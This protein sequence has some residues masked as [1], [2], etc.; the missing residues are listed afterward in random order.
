MAG[1]KRTSWRQFQSLKVN[2][3][4]LSKQAKRAHSSTVRHAHKFIVSRW[5]NIRFVRRHVI[6][7]LVLVGVLIAAVGLQL[8]W[9][10]QGYTVSAPVAGGTYAEATLGPVSSLN[11]LYVATSAEMSISRL[12]FSSLYSYDETGHLRGDIATN[13]TVNDKGTVYTLKLR[14][15]AR[16]HDG[17]KLTA[18]DVVYTVDLIK[19]PA[20]RSTITG[21]QDINA[22]AL[23]D[24]TVEFTLPA[25]YASFPHALTFAILPEH[26]LGKNAPTA[27]RESDFSQSPVGSGPFRLS[28]LQTLDTASGR[29]IV[30]ML[31]N[32]R[33]YRGAP[34]IAR[35]QLH[36]YGTLNAIGRALR[37]S[38]VNAATD[39]TASEI[40]QVD[41]ARYDVTSK[42]INDG[43]YALFNTNNDSLK[44]VLVRQAL[45]AAT[46]TN[47]IRAQLSHGVKRLDLPFIDGQLTGEVPTAPKTDTDHAGALLDQAGWKLQADG[48]RYKD[49]R[50]LKLRIASLK[51][52]EYEKTLELLSNQW[53]KVGVSIEAQVLGGSDSNVR[54]I[55]DYLQ[56]RNFDVLIY[57]LTIGGDPD[58]YAYWHSSQATLNGL[59]FSNYSNGSSDD[60][61]VSA[62]SR[63][64][65]ALR[66]AKYLSFARQWL[67]DAPAVGLYQ[68]VMYYVHSRDSQTIG[69]DAT[70]VSPQDRYSGVLY[71]TVDKGTVYKT[72]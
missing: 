7:W 57:E 26:I 40:Q 8:S 27:L 71:W 62:R 11:P 47:V 35:F 29:K 64:E 37:T 61:L 25:T 32:D 16:W 10:Q 31:P 6:G 54:V 13:M 38:E 20:V 12:L 66:N 48:L 42:P 59:N 34:K 4:R 1:E 23:D 69:N 43:V 67:S 28:Y 60:A 56:P 21:W 3:K 15:D 9:F 46:N 39:L 17:T 44:D 53:R 58:V 55:Q 18:K 5:D 50:P 51:G 49:G 22:K 2:R 70:L 68:P 52:V 19:N 72:P 36:V 45:Q 63:I 41:K 14:Q 24:Y 33:Y 65:P 30:H